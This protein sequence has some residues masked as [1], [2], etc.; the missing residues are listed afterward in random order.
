MIPKCVHNWYSDWDILQL[1]WF[2]AWKV[3]WGQGH[4]VTKYNTYWRWSEGPAWVC[5]LLSSRHLVCT[6]ST[7]GA[8]TAKARFPLPEF[9]A[10]V[11]G[12][13]SRVRFLTPELMA[14]VDGCQK[15]HQS[16]RAVNSVR[17]LGPS[18]RVVETGL[19]TVVQLYTASTQVSSDS[20]WLMMQ[21]KFERFNAVA[22]SKP[23]VITLQLS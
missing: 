22:G 19:N 21:V 15:T 8:I 9:T 11:Y 5:T 7:T 1:V 18:T 16:S 17:E 12:P 14:R 4:R 23:T 20:D 6:S 2:S 3:C 13:W 10:R